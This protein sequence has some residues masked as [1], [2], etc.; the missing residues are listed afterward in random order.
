M[1]LLSAVIFLYILLGIFVILSISDIYHILPSK[2]AKR[3]SLALF[4]VILMVIFWPIFI[5]IWGISEIIDD[6]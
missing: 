3:K 5:L 2:I 1:I 4:F 6:L